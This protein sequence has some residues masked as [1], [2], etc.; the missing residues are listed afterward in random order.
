MLTNTLSQVLLS[1]LKQKNLRM[2]TSSFGFIKVLGGEEKQVLLSN[3]TKFIRGQFLLTSASKKF[4]LLKHFTSHIF[5]CLKQTLSQFVAIAIIFFVIFFFIYDYILN[6]LNL[7]FCHEVNLH[8]QTRST[9]EDNIIV[10]RDLQGQ[11]M[12]LLH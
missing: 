3:L 10:K 5:V 8:I 6:L 11:G 9:S 12:I 2:L 4:K 7:I 1:N